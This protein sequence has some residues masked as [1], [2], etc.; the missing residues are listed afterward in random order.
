M[1][2]TFGILYKHRN[3]ISVAILYGALSRSYNSPGKE[4]K[5]PGDVSIDRHKRYKVQK[6]LMTEESK[7]RMLTD[8]V[9]QNCD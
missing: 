9:Q 7:L 2:I 3:E 6:R 4:Y 5:V 1:T 8:D